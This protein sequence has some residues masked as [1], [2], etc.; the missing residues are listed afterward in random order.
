MES[1]LLLIYVVFIQLFQS[2]SLKKKEITITNKTNINQ[3]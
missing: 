2:F 3:Q 1:T